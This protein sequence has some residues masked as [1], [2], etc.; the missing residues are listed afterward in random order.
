MSQDFV[1]HFFLM[2]L[3]HLDPFSV[4]KYFQIWFQMCFSH[5]CKKTVS[6]SWVRLGSVMAMLESWSAMSLTP[7]ES[8]SP[9]S[10][11]MQILKWC[12]CFYKDFFSPNQKLLSLI[13]EMDYHCIEKP[14]I[15]FLVQYWANF[16]WMFI[17]VP[18]H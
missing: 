3:T 5:L 7:P 12:L 17:Y 4:L 15:L 10:I 1:I 16:A 2:I 8:D 14:Y 13:K 9:V 18:N 6:C 11:S